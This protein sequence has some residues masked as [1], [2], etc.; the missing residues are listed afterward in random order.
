MSS[1][2]K[3]NN[4]RLFLRGADEQLARQIKDEIRVVLAAKNIDASSVSDDDLMKLVDEAIAEASA[5]V[6][7]DSQRSTDRSKNMDFKT[8]IA[9]LRERART[10]R[11]TNEVQTIY[12]DIARLERAMQTDT[13]LRS[14]NGS[15]REV[16]KPVFEIRAGESNEEFRARAVRELAVRAL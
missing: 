3:L 6:E 9:E 12:A 2:Q 16:S 10:T 5:E 15:S 4:L 7:S 13:E 8:R 14:P 1:R 11:D